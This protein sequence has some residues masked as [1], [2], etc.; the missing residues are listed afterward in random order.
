MSRFIQTLTRPVLEDN[1]ITVQ[2]LGLCSALAVTKSLETAFAMSA[3]V[4]AVLVG[5]NAVISLLRG[6]IP[7]PT[8]LVVQITII[9]SMVIVT[10]QLIAAF[11]PELSRQ[12][13]IFVS[14]IITNCIILGRAEAF[15]MTHGVTESIAD[16]LGNALGYLLLL[17]CVGAIRELLGRGALFGHQLLPL[18][19]EGGWFQPLEILHLPPA[20][21]FLIALFI[22][23]SSVLRNRSAKAAP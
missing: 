7:H 14:L 1:P 13:S 4:A 23:L 22:G 15:A 21:F 2:L 8:R 11:A 10:D 9:A 5:S 18:A 3:A 16:A 19:R 17:T 12:L 20:G 6:V